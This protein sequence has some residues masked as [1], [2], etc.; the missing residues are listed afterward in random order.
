M[1]SLHIKPLSFSILVITLWIL[2]LI[3]PNIY[4][5]GLCPKFYAA[6]N[7]SNRARLEKL[8]TLK[9]II[10][11]IQL[12]IDSGN[13]PALSESAL[14]YVRLSS[15]V[16]NLKDFQAQ[17]LYENN[18]ILTAQRAKQVSKTDSCCQNS[19]MTCAYSRGMKKMIDKEGTTSLNVHLKPIPGESIPFQ[20]VSFFETIEKLK[21]LFP[22]VNW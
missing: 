14:S 22:K 19:C 21:L 10:A 9:T 6:G 3:Y 20:M 15:R 1:K 18:W 12:R 17:Q 11:Q 5:S 4:A 8:E 16:P 13:A 2:F 7:E